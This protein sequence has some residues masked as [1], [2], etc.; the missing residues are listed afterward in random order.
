MIQ[1]DMEQLEANVE[2]GTQENL[3]AT[4]EEKKSPITFKTKSLWQIGVH[5]VD[6][7]V[8]SYLLEE[9]EEIRP[10]L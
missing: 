5:K 9:L 6:E 7:E 8:T 3:E 10:S 4:S 1:L 2:D